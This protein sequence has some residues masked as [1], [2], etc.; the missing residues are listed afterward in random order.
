[1]LS[2]SH[3]NQ[4]LSGFQ[5]NVF[6]TTRNSYR[7]RLRGGITCEQSLMETVRNI[8][9]LTGP[10][11]QVLAEKSV[12]Q[13][14]A[15]FH[16]NNVDQVPSLD[17]NLGIAYRLL[18]QN[19]TRNSDYGGI[20]GSAFLRHKPS[21][22]LMASRGFKT[23]RS[24]STADKPFT[25]MNRTSSDGDHSSG[26]HEILKHLDIPAKE[27]DKLNIAL[28]SY[29]A[30]LPGNGEQFARIDEV[31][32]HLDIPAS[33]KE[34]INVALLSYA[35]GASRG[36][37]FGESL[38][39]DSKSDGKKKKFDWSYLQNFKN[40]IVLL[41]FLP[42][43]GYL[44]FKLFSGN[45]QIG[46]G[47]VKEVSPEEIEV[48][49]DD[50][51]GCDEAKDELL[52]VVD[53]LTNPEKFSNLGGKLP[54][55][56]LLVGPP[57]TGK[58]LMA[59]A[60]AGEAGVP[61]F[62]ASGSEFDEVLVG[63]GAK[64]VRDLFKAAKARAPCVL[65]IDEIDSVGGKRTNSG[66]HPYASQ[67]INQL[68][69]EMDGFMSNEGVI[70]LGATN[71]VDVLDSALLRPGRFDTQVKVPNPDIKGRIEILKLYMSKIKHDNSIDVEK[72]AKL[73]V[74]FSGA[75]LFNMVNTSA[76][77]AAVDGKE[78]VSMAEFEYSHDKFVL[79]TDWKSRVRD[80]VDL[81][82]T[83]Y[84][85]AG[86]TLVAY[87][88]ED[89]T[90]LHKVTIVAKGNSG[91]HTAFLPD[92]EMS[93]RTKAQY[94]ATMDVSMGGRA[95]EELIFG[96]DKITG[97]ASSDLQQATQISEYMVKELGMSEKIGLR[98][99]KKDEMSP[100]SIELI[101]IEINKQLNESYKRA[102]N[103]LKSHRQ[104]LELLAESLLHYETLDSD[105]IRSI[106]ENKR[107]PTKVL[108]EKA[109]NKIKKI[110]SQ[111]IENKP[112][113]IPVPDL[114]PGPPTGGEVVS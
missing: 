20:F 56:V 101:D 48:T 2:F 112:A 23:K 13:L 82:I 114:V 99:V 18:Q 72:L 37:R 25:N 81:E 57:G 103:I 69:S 27:K 3:T 100:A 65:F 41:V 93:L 95:A 33:E 98:I 38:G 85:E 91:G 70:V 86:H 74:G 9:C 24:D 94:N 64:R 87:F 1:M 35:A 73:T 59:R 113:G 44:L 28:L 42:P 88:T 12:G 61:F 77:R 62:H 52:E 4:F 51:K 60:V 50:V 21:P 47:A 105:D 32:R 90:P 5:G 63:Q 102:I 11:I 31:L 89:S 30:G 26:V 10:E 19:A 40:A 97:G 22:M 6:R 104:E 109:D 108:I 96:K 67:T 71:R 92:R 8:S 45:I 16:T 14:N 17:Q 55:G 76:I 49:F 83:A 43:L 107:P 7:Q 79:G 34:K 111:P 84:H 39:A 15:F 54:K 106:V 53:F 75:D 66:L 36:V 110:A 78:F 68:L 58:T 46:R 80:K 29:A